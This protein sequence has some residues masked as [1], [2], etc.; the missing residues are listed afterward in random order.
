MD[1]KPSVKEKQGNGKQHRTAKQSSTGEAAR[2][3]GLVKGEDGCT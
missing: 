1:D 3:F 2:L